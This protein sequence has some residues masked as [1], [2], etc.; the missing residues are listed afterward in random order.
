[1]L[2]RSEILRSAW[3]S[4]RRDVLKGWGV[5]RNG[6]FSRSHFAYCLRQA[7]AVAKDKAAVAAALPQGPV[8]IAMGAV[9]LLDAV[10]AKR[11]ED[12]RNELLWQDMGERIDW[13]RRNDLRAELATLTAA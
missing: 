1:M 8:A 7:W 10:S 3:S 4:Y 5:E 9:N 2:N 6:P 13:N 12:I 11:A